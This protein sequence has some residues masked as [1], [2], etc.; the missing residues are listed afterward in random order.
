MTVELK[1]K[2]VLMVNR[3]LLRVI[4]Q[5]VRTQSVYFVHTFVPIFVLHIN[6]TVCHTLLIE[7]I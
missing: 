3:E 4:C 6:Y 2:G 1:M 7:G 5:G